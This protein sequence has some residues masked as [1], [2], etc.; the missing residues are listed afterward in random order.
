MAQFHFVED[1][2]RHVARLV[3]NY[4][5]DEAMS[6][7]IGGKYEEIGD[8]ASD[9]VI[10]AGARDGMSIFDFGCGSG[11]VASALSRKVRI[12][13]F[14]GTDVVQEL[15]DYAAT[16]TPD[17]FEF[18]CHRKLSIPADDE[19]LDLIYAFSVFTHLLHEESYIYMRDMHRALK[20][21]GRLLFS[22]LEFAKPTHWTQFERAM[23]ARMKG[24]QRSLCT[25]IDRNQL[26]VWAR[27]LHFE[28]VEYIEGDE[29][30]WDRR[31][32]GQSAV[33]LQKT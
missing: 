29:L 26:T 23:L 25:F 18:K 24:E 10:H 8:I 13:R 14:I 7:A 21:E 27:Q 1:Y 16:K 32:L 19:S 30:R 2:Q 22:F 20:P 31:R 12:G 33:I 28:I 17:Y 9:V 6:L 5:I 4:P 15:L 3:R 11:R